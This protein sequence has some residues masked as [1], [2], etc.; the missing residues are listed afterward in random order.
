[1]DLPRTSVPRPA[2]GPLGIEIPQT[3]TALSTRV[4]SAGNLSNCC[5]EKEASADT[6]VD[7]QTSDGGWVR[8][9]QTVRGLN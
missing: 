8:S 1:M 4:F 7:T 3:N 5:A 9:S 6:E 2:E